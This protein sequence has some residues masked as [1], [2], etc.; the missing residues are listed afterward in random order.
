MLTAIVGS[1]LLLTAFLWT[2]VKLREQRE[3]ANT[4]RIPNDETT[5]LLALFYALCKAS[6]EYFR[7]RKT[8]PAVISGA[9]DGLMEMGYLKAPEYDALRGMAPLFSVVITEKAGYGIC[10]LNTTASLTSSILDRADATGRGMKFVDYKE[11]RYVTLTKPIKNNYIN[12]TLPLPVNP[13]AR[14]PTP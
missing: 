10:L 12:L 5:V 2:L 4:P 3:A 1:F 11:G 9:H 14:K 7:D 13:S 6:I 8:Y